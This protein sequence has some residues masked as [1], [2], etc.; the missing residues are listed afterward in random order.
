MFVFIFVLIASLRILFPNRFTEYVRLPVNNRYVIIYEKKEK[1]LQL[2][3]LILALIQWL[4]LSLF[5]YLWLDYRQ[6]SLPFGTPFFFIDI[7]L[8]ILILL[9]LKFIVQRNI[10]QL[11]DLKRFAKS[12]LF[13]R[14]A[15]SNYGGIVMAITLFIVSYALSLREIYFYII[16]IIYLIVNILSWI[17]IIK[18]NQNQL[19]RYI[20]YF[21]LYL[22]TFEIAPCIFLYHLVVSA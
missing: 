8:A 19:K 13:S 14:L 15:Y 20:V 2:F 17:T 21:I 7:A 11:F 5:L 16:I 18:I 9:L 4:S 22:C 1:K 10:Q 6:F 12:Y 3:T